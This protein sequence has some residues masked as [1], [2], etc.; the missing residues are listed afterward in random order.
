MKRY[1]IEIKNA[2]ILFKNF[3]GQEKQAMVKGHMQIVNEAGKRN[4]SVILDPEKSEI[5][6]GEPGK[7]ELVTDPDFGRTLADLG[8]RVTVRPG[9]EEGDH[10]EYRLAIEVRYPKPTDK[11][12]NYSPELFLVV[13]GKKPVLLDEDTVGSTL[14]RCEIVRADIV[15]NNSTTIDRNTGEERA[16]CWCNEGYFTIRKSRIGQD[17][18]NYD[19][20]EELPFE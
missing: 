9:K 4:F 19:G 15:I 20:P 2:Q 11:Y 3:S 13:P 7:T 14:D 12:N 10:E 5:Y 8:Y 18:E 16:K 1:S 6:F 17:Y